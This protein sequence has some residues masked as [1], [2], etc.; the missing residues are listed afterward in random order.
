M[1]RNKRILAI[2]PA[3]LGSK[4]LPK[5]NIKLFHGKPLLH[6]AIEA[7][8]E[9]KEI[10]KVVLSTES[11]E[12]IS[13][14]DKFQDLE[15]IRRPVDLSTD[16]ASSISVMRHVKDVEES[17]GSR[18]DIVTLIQAT[19][20]LVIEKDISETVKLHIRSSS[21]S[22]FT[23]S[24]VEHFSPNK[25]FRLISDNIIEPYFDIEADNSNRQNYSSAHIRNGSCYSFTTE[26]LS[27]NKPWGGK[28]TAYLVPQNRNIDIDSKLDFEIAEFLYGRLNR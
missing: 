3:R 17:N 9:V 12:I 23:I 8:L 27:S 15:I 13:T 14:C 24:K 21:D 19:N 6:Y 2:I 7:A 5:K 25:I 4:G 10:D 11:S 1:Y 22:C 16:T 20:P 28:S 18:Y 26:R